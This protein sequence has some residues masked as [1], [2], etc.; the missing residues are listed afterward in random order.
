MKELRILS[1]N[2]LE[3]VCEKYGWYD[4]GTTEEFEALCK[5]LRGDFTA[6]VHMSADE[7]ERVAR[8]IL[9]HTQTINAYPITRIME[10]L[11]DTCYSCFME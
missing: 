7:L 4:Q 9:A 1:P 10:V 5:T 8:D 6:A 2:R 3:R 11:A